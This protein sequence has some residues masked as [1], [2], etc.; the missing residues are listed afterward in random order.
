MAYKN[1]YLDARWQ[2]KRLEIMERD[3]W[4]CLN[5]HDTFQLSVHHLY[6]LP[7]TEIWDY[8]NECYVTLCDKCHKIIHTDLVKISGIIA[9]KL[10][11]KRLD[12]ATFYG[13]LD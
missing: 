7:D 10:L 2:K 9:F 4:E 3:K 8:D 5:C 6:Y 1:A 12:L 11:T 13:R